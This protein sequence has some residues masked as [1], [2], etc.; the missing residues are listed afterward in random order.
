MSFLNSL[1]SSDDEEEENEHIIIKIVMLGQCGTGKT[2]IVIRFVQNE[3]KENTKPTVGANFFLRS[4]NFEDQNFC[5]RLW[6]TSGQEKFDSLTPLYYR[7]A[8]IAILVYDVKSISSLEKV[9]Y[10]V[11]EIKNNVKVMPL[12]LIVGNKMDE[13]IEEYDYETVERAK[14][15]AQKMGI[16]V[17]QAS[18][19]TGEGINEIFEN[20]TQKLI[21][22]RP[23]QVYNE[24]E[25]DNSSNFSTDQ[26]SLQTNNNGD[27][28]K[29][30]KLQCC[31]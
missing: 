19:K 10:W 15:I 7:N 31:W 14:V 23:S 1:S 8:N 28:N 4:M 17:A 13:Y 16:G 30:E 18:A 26:V 6:D 22:E 11:K 5:L 3:F 25:Q 12:L 9:K 21:I 24:F 2:S 20:I 27:Q 29:K